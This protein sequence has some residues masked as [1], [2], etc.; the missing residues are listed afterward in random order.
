[1][2]RVLALISVLK[3]SHMF[4]CAH[5]QNFFYISFIQ[6][7]ARESAQDNPKLLYIH[8]VQYNFLLT[9]IL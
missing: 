1:M 7:I 3:K 8:P 2:S 4:P 9:N 5:T 6:Q